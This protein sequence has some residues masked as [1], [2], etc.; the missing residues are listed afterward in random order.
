MILCGLYS[1]FNYT[2]ANG[3]NIAVFLFAV[4]FQI[5]LFLLNFIGSCVS[6]YFT[7]PACIY[8]SLGKFSF[9]EHCFTKTRYKLA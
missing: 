4:L 8:Q 1:V 6:C 5:E 9:F 3:N 7:M 2:S